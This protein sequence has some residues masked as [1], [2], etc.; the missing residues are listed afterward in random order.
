MEQL[1]IAPEF[2]HLDRSKPHNVQPKRT[3]CGGSRGRHHFKPSKHGE[4][5][6]VEADG[7]GVVVGP[8]KTYEEVQEYTNGLV[9]K[10]GD[11]YESSTTSWSGNEYV[12]FTKNWA[13]DLV[14]E[15]K[16]IDFKQSFKNIASDNDALLAVG[17]GVLS[18]AFLYCIIYLVYLRK[19]AFDSQFEDY[20]AAPDAIP[21]YFDEKLPLYEN[22]SSD[23]QE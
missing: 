19:I 4:G 14:Q 8:F 15:V 1:K 22:E 18:G 17:A 5:L 2:K 12:Q 10:D 20:E 23:D 13:N 16:D 6:K 9:H 7:E 21:E 3:G 11:K